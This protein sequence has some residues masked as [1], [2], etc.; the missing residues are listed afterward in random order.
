MADVFRERLQASLRHL[1]K[2][3]PKQVDVPPSG[4]SSAWTPIRKPSTRSARGGVCSWPRRRP[5]GRMHVEYAV[6]KGCN[7]FM[8]KSFA[9]DAPGVHRVLKAG[10]EAAKKNLKVAGGLMCRHYLPLAEA[11]AQIHDGADRRGDHLLGLPRARPGGIHA[12]RRA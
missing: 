7:V 4:S 12:E 1:S 6:A 8:E 5:S 3:F 11:I 9:V 10:E 2:R